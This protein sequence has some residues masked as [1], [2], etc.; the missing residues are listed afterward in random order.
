MGT[1]HCGRKKSK[2]ANECSVCSKKRMNEIH[3]K[4][5]AIVRTGKCPECGAGL[6]RNLSITGW[7]QCEQFGAEGFRK[8]PLRPSCN[9]Q[10]FT[11]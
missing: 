1:C 10:C 11:E 6:K 8:D 4:S 9:F 2:Y 7:W 3:E 5:L